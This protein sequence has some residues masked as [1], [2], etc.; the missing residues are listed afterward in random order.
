MNYEAL[1]RY[2]EAMDKLPRLCDQ[3]ANCMRYVE[4]SA[5]SVG[6]EAG[7]LCGHRPADADPVRM[8]G[9]IRRLKAEIERAEA[10]NGEISA[11]AEIINTHAEACGRKKVNIRHD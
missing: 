8:A 9:K 5:R 6:Y 10:L 2:T 4:E 1:G 3:M 11:L 7:S